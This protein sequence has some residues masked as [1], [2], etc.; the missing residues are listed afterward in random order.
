MIDNNSI[1]ATPT[2]L[3]LTQLVILEIGVSIRIMDRI[4]RDYDTLGTYLLNDEDGGIMRTIEHDKNKVTGKI[5]NEVFH[6]W[7]KG[8]G[9]RNG[10][11]RN[12]WETLVK[13]LKHSKLM[14]LA[15]EIE[16]VLNFC[17]EKTLH[18][19]DEECVQEHMHEARMETKSFLQPL[20]SM[21]V[22]VIVG[23]GA[24]L[25]IYRNR[26]KHHDSITYILKH[27][28]STCIFHVA[29]VT[30]STP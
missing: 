4:G 15:D 18:I 2:M 25:I 28:N 13:C 6:R 22:A 3:Q 30:Q 7:V 19:D 16:T 9:Q 27:V 8:Q 21:F 12:T 1:D 14:A 11:N 20:I 26:C 23:S 17:T 29:K 5:L 24:A 10:K